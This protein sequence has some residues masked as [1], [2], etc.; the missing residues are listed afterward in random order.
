MGLAVA[1]FR[2]ANR[3][4][5]VRA[6]THHVVALLRAAGE[7][8]RT[9]AS[10]AEVVFDN[11]E[12]AIFTLTQETAGMWHFE[13]E[14]GAFG[15]FATLS[16]VNPVTGWLGGGFAFTGGSTVDCGVIPVH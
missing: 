5:G 14:R 13:D 16:K 2:S 9:Q 4:L 3:D 6:A 10:P 8:A 7:H 12:H 11:Q 1:M 15:T